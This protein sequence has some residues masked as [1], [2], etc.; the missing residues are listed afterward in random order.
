VPSETPNLPV[1]AEGTCPKAFDH[2][3]V[4]VNLGDSPNTPRIDRGRAIFV[5]NAKPV[6]VPPFCGHRPGP[7]ECEQWAPCAEDQDRVFGEGPMWW[8]AA[9]PGTACNRLSWREPDCQVEHPSRTCDAIEAEE[10]RINGLDPKACRRPDAFH[11]RDVVDP[12]GANGG[13]PGV[14]AICVAP[15]G[16]PEK[17][18]CRVWG[19]QA[20]GGW[21]RIE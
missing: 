1:P 8:F 11:G 17:R 21:R 12:S 16:S 15:H 7:S 3:P 19:L 4:R 18:V 10:D 9:Y 13:P 14:R 2:P 5:F 6:D 20:D